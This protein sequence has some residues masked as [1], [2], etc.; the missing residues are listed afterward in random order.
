MKFGL[1][2][3][4]LVFGLALGAGG[5]HVFLTPTPIAQAQALSAEQ[6]ARLQA[7]YDQLQKE[8]AQWQKVLDETRAKKNTLQGDV[9]LLDAQ[10]RKA[11][12]EIRQRGNTIAR[13]AGEINEKTRHISTLERR[14]E[15]G[16]A[17]L[18]ELL[19]EKHEVE[20]T[21]LAVLVLGAQGLSE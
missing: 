12:A 18:A 21:S 17:S 7:E 10:I 6:R 16:R 4:V 2:T 14:L 1:Y 19:R 3:G 11:Q 5:F 13:L 9:T 20:E 15:E 8:I